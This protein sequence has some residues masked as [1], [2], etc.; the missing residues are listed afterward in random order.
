[1][2]RQIRLVTPRVAAMAGNI[3]CATLQS[4]EAAGA[5]AAK[6]PSMAV[7]I[8]KMKGPLDSAAA[9]QRSCRAKFSSRK[10]ILAPSSTDSPFECGPHYS[11]CRFRL[12]AH[13]PH[14]GPRNLAPGAP[15]PAS[16]KLVATTSTT[17]PGASGFRAA[18]RR[19]G[20]AEP[21]PSRN[22][23]RV[24]VWKTIVLR[25]SYVVSARRPDGA[26]ALASFSC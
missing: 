18:T 12:T 23:A 17:G 7:F 4:Q 8:A 13:R 1:M 9:I 15:R 10:C 2:E 3:T 26:A 25:L 6:T 21:V 20:L 16:G 11:L 14:S 5:S 24:D 22:M 19:P